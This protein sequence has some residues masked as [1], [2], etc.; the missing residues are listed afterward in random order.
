M[1]NQRAKMNAIRCIQGY[2]I[3]IRN[4]GDIDER[5]DSWADP[6]LQLKNDIR[7]ASHDPRSISMLSE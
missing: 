7:R 2:V 1:C 3:Q 4:A 5:V 6:A